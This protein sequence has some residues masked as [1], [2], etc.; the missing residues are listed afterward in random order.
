M[1]AELTGK[2]GIV[3]GAGR[4][5]GREIATA[6]EAAGARVAVFDLDGG[7]AREA[8]EELGGESIGLE[9][10]VT[11]ADAVEAAVAEVVDTYG[12]LDYL[13]NN[14][15]IR[16]VASLADESVDAWRRTIDVNLTGT[17]I[18]SQMAIRQMRRTGGG[19]IVNLASMAGE[20]ALNE[21][22]AYNC[23]KAGIVALTKSIAVEFGEAGINCNAIAPGVIETPLSAPY[24]EDES[25]VRV[26]RENSP[27]G[28]WGQPNEV[29]APAVFLCSD[30]AAFVHGATLF[31]DGGWVA[32]KGY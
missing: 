11:D 32:G 1:G 17:F 8:A 12:R 28:R 21:R 31:V 6:F 20:L 2:S 22:A 14:A 5:I 3:T 24:F 7:A 30:A 4:G 15:G 19:K 23:S 26:L 29:A 9:V 16:H 27:L 10:D 25:M 18:C 13:V